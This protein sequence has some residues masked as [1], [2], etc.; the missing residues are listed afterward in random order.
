M[1]L[2]N[3]SA[4]PHSTEMIGRYGM[5]LRDWFAGQ[6]LGYLGQRKDIT[7]RDAEHIAAIS[8]DLADAMLAERMKGE[9]YD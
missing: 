4:F 7:I 2:D 6:A 1:Q 9:D 3:P 8:Y 5:T